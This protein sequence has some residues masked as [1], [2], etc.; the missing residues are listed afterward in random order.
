[1][2]KIIFRADGNSVIGLGHFFRLLALADLVKRDFAC[3]CAIREPSEFVKNQ[4]EKA[5]IGLI[6]LEPLDYGDLSGEAESNELPFDLTHHLEGNEIVVLDG[7]RFGNEYQ[8]KI[9]ETGCSLVHIDDV[10]KE[11][12][13]A[14]VIINHALSA[15]PSQYKNTRASLFL[16]PDYSLMRKEF[17]EAT[18]KIKAKRKFDTAFVCFGGADTEELAFKISSFLC[19]ND[20]P[21]KAINILNSSSYTGDLEK[22]KYLATNTGKTVTVFQNLSAAEIIAVMT[23]SDFAMISASNIAYECTC[24]GLPMVIGYYVDH[25]IQFYTALKEKQN[26]QAVEKW[27]DLT[28]SSLLRAINKLVVDYNPNT[29]SLIDGLQQRRFINLFTSLSEPKNISFL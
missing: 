17:L 1:M 6:A 8:Q 26:V 24:T 21:V 4:L 28:A 29:V 12:P 27:Q 9:K 19:H 15:S 13:F 3:F 16:G 18:R 5:E 10:C 25:Q 2:Q 7:Y 20:S 23:D 14:D 11:Y 22:F